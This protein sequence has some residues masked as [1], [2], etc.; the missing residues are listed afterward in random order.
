[1]LGVITIVG[2]AG[3]LLPA[4]FNLALGGRL[5]PARLWVLGL[6]GVVTLTLV[7]VFR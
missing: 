7:F 3:L 5:T 4:A 6:L 1:L 2:G